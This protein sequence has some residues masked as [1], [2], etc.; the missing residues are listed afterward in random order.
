MQKFRHLTINF[1]LCR[2]GHEHTPTCQWGKE[3]PVEVIEWVGTG[4]AIQHRYHP[5]S[6]LE[7]Y[8]ITHIASGRL[9][10]AST[11]FT[12][13]EAALWLRLIKGLT[14]W[15]QPAERLR[16]HEE[17]LQSVHRVREQAIRQYVRMIQQKGEVR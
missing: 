2:P 7:D 13:V 16:E 15:T 11:T 17:L 8:G 4:L 9:L 10:T 3:F 14:D 6:D 5:S 1:T 12:L